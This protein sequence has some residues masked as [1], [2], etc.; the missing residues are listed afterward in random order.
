MGKTR[1]GHLG[2]GS[3]N[4]GI[5]HSGCLWEAVHSFFL[6]NNDLAIDVDS[7]AIFAVVKACNR[8]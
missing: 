2:V 8:V 4:E 3:P 1:V 5:H 6:M 7:C